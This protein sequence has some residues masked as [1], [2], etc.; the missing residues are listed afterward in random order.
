MTEHIPR[1]CHHCHAPLTARGSCTSTDHRY[2][3][4][5]AWC[6]KLRPWLHGELARW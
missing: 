2:D 6:A 4:V 3:P 1:L 5:D